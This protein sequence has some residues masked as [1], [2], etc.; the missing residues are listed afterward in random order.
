MLRDKPH[1][2]LLDHLP[3]LLEL[4]H[5]LPVLDLACGNGQNGLVLAQH[6]IPV[7]F[8]DHSESALAMVEQSMKSDRLTGKVWQVDLEQMDVNPFTGQRYSAI[9]GFRYL[10][11]PLFS[12]LKKAIMPGGLIVYETFTIDQRQFGRPENPDFLL[13]PGEL[14]NWFQKWETIHYFEGIRPNPDRGIAQLVARKPV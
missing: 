1:S 2:L 13:R 5:S 7:V 8:A 3:L 6:A 9:L 10:H 12:A 11:R 4:D 14:K